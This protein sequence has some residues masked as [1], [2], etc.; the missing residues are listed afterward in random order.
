MTYNNTEENISDETEMGIIVR[1]DTIEMA[2]DERNP[3][4]PDRNRPS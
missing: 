3:G 4:N 2:F 1:I